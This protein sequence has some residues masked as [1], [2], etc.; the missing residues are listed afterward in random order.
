[1]CLPQIKLVHI[2]D[3]VH[4][5][6]DGTERRC[7]TTHVLH[8]IMPQMPQGVFQGPLWRFGVLVGHLPSAILSLPAFVSRSPPDNSCMYPSWISRSLCW[9]GIVR[10]ITPL[11]QSRNE[12]NS[13]S[14][15]GADKSG[16]ILQKMRL[17]H[18]RSSQSS[19]HNQTE[20]PGFPSGRLISSNEG[21]WVLFHHDSS[22]APQTVQTA[23]PVCGTKN[24]VSVRLYSAPQLHRTIVAI[25]RICASGT[26]KQVETRRHNQ[27]NPQPALG[28][29]THESSASGG[30]TKCLRREA[31][32]R[33]AIGITNTR[34]SEPR[35]PPG[36]ELAGP[37]YELVLTSF[38]IS[39]N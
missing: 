14:V 28:C 22:A 10:C 30:Q 26:P 35:L 11:A 38:Q 33:R 1:L 16:F 21:T 27:T 6:S 4:P 34:C 9:A 29:E 31:S 8:G 2:G 3:A 13:S 20:L 7:R 24:F 18:R 15:N 5:G 17:R 25:L 36:R 23:S 39:A 19:C 32:M 12:T 37:E